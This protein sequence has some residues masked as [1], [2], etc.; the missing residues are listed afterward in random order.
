[1][2]NYCKATFYI[3]VT[4]YMKSFAAPLTKAEALRQQLEDLT[5]EQFVIIQNEYCP[6]C[7][8]RVKEVGGM[9]ELS[10]V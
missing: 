7:G 5:G 10:K 9:N 6:M 3:K 4:K 2:C 1:M 8:E